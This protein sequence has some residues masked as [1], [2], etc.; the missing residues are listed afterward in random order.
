[1]S[2]KEITKI[3]RQ[4][5]AIYKAADLLKEEFVGK[6]V[7][8]VGENSTVSIIFSITN[9]MHLCGI[10]YRRGAA[11]FFQNALDRKIN[12]QDIKIKIDST[13]FLKL[14]VIGSVSLLLDKEISIVGRGIYSSLRYD[15][16]IRTRKKILALSLM[17]NGLNYVPISLLNLTSKEIGPGQ[18]VT[19]IFSEDLISG[20]VKS[21]MEIAD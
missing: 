1:M 9:F 8:Y 18:K 21:I 11:L 14:Q 16:A 20:E 2:I 13:T 4:L 7:T 10:H 6:K 12:L 3:T 17:Q 15:S 19:C 5:N